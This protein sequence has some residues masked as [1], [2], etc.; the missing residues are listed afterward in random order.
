M[1]PDLLSDVQ[2]R[3]TASG[4]QR[5][6]LYDGRGLY[7][8]MTPSG[9]RWWRFKY[10]FGG[11]EKLLSMGVYPDTSLKMAREKR[12]AARTLLA[13][14]V[15]P[16]VARKAAKA[17][18]AGVALDNFEAVAR[19]F[20][21]TRQSEWSEAHSRRWIERLEKD[22]FPYL[23]ASALPAISAPLL[24]QALQRVEARGVRETVHSLQQAC[25]QVFGTASRLV[26]LSETRPRTC[27][28][29]SSRFSSRTWRPSPSREPLALL[30]RPLLTI[31]AAP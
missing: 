1:K 3:R 27:A 5:Q 26:E 25:G 19:E 15:D 14:E 21:E 17:S 2:I 12:D 6:R 20:H 8:E 10:R 24:L 28:A 16:G 23:G 9:G 31:G 4:P 11:K 29:H 18:R 30:S 22:I 13:S 7:L